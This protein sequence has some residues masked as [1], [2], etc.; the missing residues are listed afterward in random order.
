MGIE[1]DSRYITTPNR[2]V[3]VVGGIVY[4]RGPQ[5][6]KLGVDEN[7]N[8]VFAPEITLEEARATDYID[9]KGYI[10]KD[11]SIW[12]FCLNKPAKACRNEY[13]Y[14]W[15]NLE[16][17]L[18]FSDPVEEIRDMYVFEKI[19]NFS[20]VSIIKNTKDNEQLFDEEEINDV[21]AATSFYVPLLRS[22]DDFLKKVIKASIIK[23]GIDIN[24]LKVKTEQKYVLPNMRSVLDNETKM[25]T[26]NFLRWMDLL[27]LC[28]DIIIY[29]DGSDTD[30]LKNPI[31]YQSSRDTLG[32][33]VNGE[34]IDLITGAF[35]M[36]QDENEEE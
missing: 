1:L 19:A 24:R 30:L 32:E 12:I 16:N 25:S 21:N 36:D 15:K 6:E 14:F 28:F 33:I 23:K 31:I 10:D 8:D 9:G 26:V 18:E 34:V 4:V 29:N 35:V 3:N 5:E 22:S 17:D 7:G 20:K 13:P 11:G 2:T 27:G